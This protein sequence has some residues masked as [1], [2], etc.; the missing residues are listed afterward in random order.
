MDSP[1]RWTL[2][3]RAGCRRTNPM[4]PRP[5]KAG[6]GARRAAGA[7]AHWVDQHE[8]RHRDVVVCGSRREP[9][10]AL[11]RAVR[12][13]VGL[14]GGGRRGRTR[15][16][17][18]PHTKNC[19]RAIHRDGVGGGGRRTAPHGCEEDLVGVRP[20]ATHTQPCPS[21]PAHDVSG[22]PSC[23]GDLLVDRVVPGWWEA[24]HSAAAC[25]ATSLPR[26]CPMSTT[27]IGSAGRKAG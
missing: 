23:C 20:P 3:K 19:G 10:P 12:E 26:L 5:A 25:I 15:P 13:G 16:P 21:P 24:R 2:G 8:A 9:R 22:A 27:S 14:W 4:P 17:T 1:V 11:N 6:F 7:Q 18:A